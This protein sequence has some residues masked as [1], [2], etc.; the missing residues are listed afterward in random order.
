MQIPE[1]V[2]DAL[3]DLR[4]SVWLCGIHHPRI[5]TAAVIFDPDLKLSGRDPHVHPD[6]RGAT[7]FESVVQC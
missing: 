3:A 1:P 4:S 7:M 2:T 6:A 5:K